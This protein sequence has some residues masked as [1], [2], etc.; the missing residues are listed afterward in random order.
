MSEIKLIAVIGKL[1]PKVK[2]GRTVV[3]DDMA[4]E[5]ADQSGHDRGDARDFGYK[6]SQ[7]LVRHLK[8]G[9]YVKLGDIGSFSVSC[10]KDK[11]L[12]VGYRAPKALNDE[13]E[14]DFRGEFVNSGNAGLDDEGYAQRWLELNPGDTV[15]MRD[16]TTRTAGGG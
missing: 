15:I 2:R 16:G 3:L 11:N 12:R 5:I 9:D 4:D 13:L 8:L 6:F 7:V 14:Q 10:D 1:R